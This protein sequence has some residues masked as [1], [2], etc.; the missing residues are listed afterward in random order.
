MGLKYVVIIVVVC[1]DLKDGGVVVFVEI[2]CVVCRK[3][4]FMFIE[5]LLFDMGGVEENLKML[6]D[7]KLDILNYNIEIVCR[8][9]D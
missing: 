7:V 3:N 9:F 5:V 4:L 8:L 1:D 2:V 6:M